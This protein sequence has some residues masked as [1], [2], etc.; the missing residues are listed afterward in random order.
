[1][2]I[3]FHPSRNAAHVSY[4]A[5]VSMPSAMAESMRMPPWCMPRANA[6]SSSRSSFTAAWPPKDS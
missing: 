2:K 6:R 4:M 1:M 3:R 5:T